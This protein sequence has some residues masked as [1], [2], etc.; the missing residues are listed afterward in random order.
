MRVSRPL[1]V[2]L[3]LIT[4]VALGGC[5]EEPSSDAGVI[6]GR[7]EL[8]WS[9]DA[10][11]PPDEPW[12][13]TLGDVE[14]WRDR[15]YVADDL[16]STVVVLDQAGNSV[17]TIGKRG[18]GP[19]EINVRNIVHMTVSPL[20]NLFVQTGARRLSKFSPSGDFLEVLVLERPS[21]G[22][23]Y[24]FSD[25]ALSV[26][27]GAGRRTDSIETQMDAPLLATFPPGEEPYYLGT[28]RLPD[29]SE[30]F[31]ETMSPGPH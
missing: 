30:T 18:Q 26:A 21:L 12:F 31:R 10:G 25:S 5:R 11:D 19:G 8:V 13:G 24:A 17:Q 14:V 9:L 16:R 7:A 15:I 28:R 27:Q 22:K 29:R 4:V 1:L 23:P 6:E 20:G 2:L 3:L